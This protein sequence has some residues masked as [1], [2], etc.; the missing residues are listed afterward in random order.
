MNFYTTP[1]PL[2]DYLDRQFECD[3]GKSHYAS[4]RTVSVGK[5]ALLD[6]PK[7]AQQEG[8]TSLYLVCDNITFDIDF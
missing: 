4:L 3:C 5:D 1:H 2:G 7:I 6:L 8:Y